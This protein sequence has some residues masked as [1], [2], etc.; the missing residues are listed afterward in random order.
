MPRHGHRDLAGQALSA[1]TRRPRGS[2]RDAAPRHASMSYPQSRA[3]ASLGQ[4]SAARP[5]RCT[6]SPVAGH[7][8]R[9]SRA[10][11]AARGSAPAHDTPASRPR[12]RESRTEGTSSAQR[13]LGSRR[14][15]R[16]GRAGDTWAER[17]HAVERSPCP[18]TEQRPAQRRIARA[19]RRHEHSPPRK[20]VILPT[21]RRSLHPYRNCGEGSD[22]RCSIP[23]HPHVFLRVTALPR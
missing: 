3:R 4:V 9:R 12:G 22:R 6:P 16:R 8:G 13:R 11:R 7:P 2:H 20:E 23:R 19:A 18:L 10:D 21:P 1:R 14:L 15:G 5:H 17:R